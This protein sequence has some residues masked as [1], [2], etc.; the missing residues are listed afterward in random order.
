[1]R[2]QL[3][4]RDRSWRL[5]PSQKPKGSLTRCCTD[6]TKNAASKLYGAAQRATFAL[7]F[8]RL[9]T[10]T[11]AEEIG[12]SLLA[13]NWKVIGETGGGSWDRKNRARVDKAPIGQKTLWEVTP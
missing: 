4:P 8:R 13:S 3:P 1:M 5:T 7:G 11:L 6:G 12:T 10:Y 2:K 9:I